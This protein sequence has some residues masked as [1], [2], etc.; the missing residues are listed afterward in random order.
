[1]TDALTECTEALRL[2]TEWREA[3][4]AI[5]DI[6]WG[7]ASNRRPEL[8]VRLGNA[9]AALMAFARTLPETKT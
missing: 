4:R 5:L 1:M 8:W 9:E 6:D 7:D 2:L 3:R